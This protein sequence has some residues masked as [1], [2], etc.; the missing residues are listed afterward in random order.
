MTSTTILHSATRAKVK[1]NKFRDVSDSRTNFEINAKS[2]STMISMPKQYGCLSR[3]P[4]ISNPSRKA[5]I[6]HVASLSL[7]LG[8]GIWILNSV[9]ISGRLIAGIDSTGGAGTPAGRRGPPG[10]SSRAALI[11][12]DH[13][14]TSSSSVSRIYCCVPA[15]DDRSHHETRCGFTMAASPSFRGKDCSLCD[16]SFCGGSS[17]NQHPSTCRRRISS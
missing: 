11:F 5:S 10:V 13:P 6:L 12:I 2:A 4:C 7:N 3:R 15:C 14:T 9:Y 17:L 1:D 16:L 8:L